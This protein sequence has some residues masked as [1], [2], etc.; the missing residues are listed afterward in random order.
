L[1]GGDDLEWHADRAL[2]P[3]IAADVMFLGMDEGWF[4]TDDAG[5]PETLDKYF[6]AERD[7]PYEAREIINGDKSTVPSLSGGVSIGD[8]IADYHVN[9]LAALEASLIAVSPAQVA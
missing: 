1:T 5:K 6:N 4:R 8:L 9:F 3:A 7:D 2:D